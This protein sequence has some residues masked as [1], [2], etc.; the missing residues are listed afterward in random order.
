MNVYN[1]SPDGFSPR[2][3]QTDTQ[4]ITAAI[5][6]LQESVNRQFDKVRST[7]DNINGRMSALEEKQKSLSEEV[8]SSPKIVT[9]ST[10]GG[11]K[12]N[13]ATPTALQV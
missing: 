11:K 3:Q 1:A 12:R 8:R 7:L 4:G 6:A 2:T 10:S 9:P 5:Q 13:R